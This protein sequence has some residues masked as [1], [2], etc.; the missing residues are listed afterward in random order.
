MS[1]TLSGPVGEMF[2]GL[3]AAEDSGGQE[4]DALLVVEF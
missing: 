3:V 2:I 1:L 4:L